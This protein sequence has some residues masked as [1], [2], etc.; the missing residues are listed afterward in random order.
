M[1]GRNYYHIL[2]LSRQATDF[3]IKN[4]YRRLALKWHP[5]KDPRNLDKFRD[6]AESYTVLIDPLKRGKFDQYGEQGLKDGILEQ[7]EYRGYQYVGDPEALFYDFFGQNSPHALLL[8]E[9]GGFNLAT[10]T[11]AAGSKQEGATEM[12]LRCSLEDFYRGSVQTLRVERQRF[13][14]EMKSYVDRKCLTIKCEQG[15][16]PGIRLR[17]KGEGNQLHPSDSKAADIIF[18]VVETAHPIFERILDTYDLLY[19]HRVSLVDAVC[20]HVIGL[21]LLDES[22]INLHVSETVSPGYEKR[23]LFHGL[24]KP[25]GECGD[26]LIRWDIQFPVLSSEKKQE[27][28]SLLG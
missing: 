2:E 9:H 28:K 1:A 23:I 13:D 24:Q 19:I 12:E 20:G 26:L 18:T 11:L 3:D 7:G 22:K 14:R 4:A 10:R 21:E 8:E 27:L 16:K 25:G 17:F 5:Q 15:W 6:V